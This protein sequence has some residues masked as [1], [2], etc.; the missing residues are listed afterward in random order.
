MKKIWWA[1]IK[2]VI[3][4]EMKKTFFAKRGLWIY[5]LAAMP[6]MLF[7]AHAIVS[8]HQ[9]S[10]SATI[11][12]RGEKM[13]T[14][15]DLRAIK[16]DMT[17]QEV[18]AILGKP[19]ITFHWTE[20]RPPQ[21]GKGTSIEVLHEDYHYSDGA[22]RFVCRDRGRQGRE[23]PYSRCEQPGP[24]LHHV[25]RRLPILFPAP[26]HLFRMPRNFH[27]PFSR[28]NPRPEPPLLFSCARY[29]AKL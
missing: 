1:Q 19:P 2:A 25:C 29:A 4:L 8:S 26:G 9:Q 3:R 5:V 11:A 14:S 7:A 16:P 15:Q 20:N 27:E 6:V 24:G 10:R 28:R 23:H 22:E 18:I 17:N 12:A 13:L 21:T